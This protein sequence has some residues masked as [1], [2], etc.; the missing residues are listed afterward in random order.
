MARWRLIQALVLID[1]GILPLVPQPAR[2]ITKWGIANNFQS[3]GIRHRFIHGL[4][5]LPDR[6]L[7]Q[8]LLLANQDVFQRILYLQ[9]VNQL[10][11]IVLIPMPMI[12]DVKP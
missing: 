10:L 7:Q 3:M 1:L 9:L 4:A 11:V 6:E 5:V 8:M 2:V 12:W